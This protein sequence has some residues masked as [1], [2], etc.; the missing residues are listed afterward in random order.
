MLFYQQFAYQMINNHEQIKFNLK[1]NA[2]KEE[3]L[4]ISKNSLYIHIY[5]V[6]L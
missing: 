5:E 2:P 1:I 6:I 4:E 3:K